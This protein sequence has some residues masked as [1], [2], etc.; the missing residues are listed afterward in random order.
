MTD[1]VKCDK[2]GKI[3]PHIVESTWLVENGEYK[4][5]GYCKICGY[6]PFPWHR[7]SK[8]KLR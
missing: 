3:T 8:N 7:E 4:A 5:A 6:R 2:C 1:D